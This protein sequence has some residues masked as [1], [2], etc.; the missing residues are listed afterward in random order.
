M[1]SIVNTSKKKV[2]SKSDKVDKEQNDNYPFAEILYLCKTKLGYSEKSAH[3]VYIGEYMEQLEV[4]KKYHN[5]EMQKM[6]FTETEKEEIRVKQNTEELP[7]WYID[8]MASQ[9]G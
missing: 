9:K 5:M 4:F 8:Y 1:F 2:H 3:H 7:Q 6:L